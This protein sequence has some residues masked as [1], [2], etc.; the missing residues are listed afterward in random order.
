M[1][2]VT[3]LP[4]ASITVAPS[5][6]AR[7]APPMASILPFASRTEPPPIRPPSPSSLIAP[8]ITDTPNGH[9]SYVAVTGS[10]GKATTPLRE[11]AADEVV[12]VGGAF[13]AAP[14]DGAD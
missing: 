5:G 13:W 7:S 4:A 8:R 1:P 14:A 3:H 9:S 12:T 11:G 6:T 2:G 10:D